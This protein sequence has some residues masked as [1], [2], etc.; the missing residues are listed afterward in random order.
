MKKLS[1]GVPVEVAGELIVSKFAD[2]AVTYDANGSPVLV[3]LD[4]DQIRLEYWDKWN[5]WMRSIHGEHRISWENCLS[6][7]VSLNWAWEIKHG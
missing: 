5:D 7:W 3:T 6:D 1:V 2:I 4:E